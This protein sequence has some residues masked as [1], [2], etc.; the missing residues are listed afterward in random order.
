MSRV[1][2]NQGLE[3]VGAFAYLPYI[4]TCIHTYMHTCIHTSVHAHVHTYTHKHIRTHVYVYI[5][6]YI[7]NI[8]SDYNMSPRG[9]WTCI[10]Y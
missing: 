3:D 5:Y 2:F 1:Q 4:H 10:V 8:Q 9:Y 7:T 6:I